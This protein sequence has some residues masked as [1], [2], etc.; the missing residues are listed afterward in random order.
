MR[1]AASATTGVQARSPAAPKLQRR[2]G[3]RAQLAGRPSCPAEIKTSNARATARTTP[4]IE[5]SI[6]GSTENTGAHGKQ[7]GGRANTITKPAE[8]CPSFEHPKPDR[9]PRGLDPGG[10]PPDFAQP[11]RLGRAAGRARDPRRHHRRTDG[12]AVSV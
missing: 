7:T 8:D 6:A 12:R 9:P 3:N 1:V 4:C 5:F 2:S 10:R 11:A